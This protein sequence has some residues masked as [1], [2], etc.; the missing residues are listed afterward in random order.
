MRFGAICLALSLLCSAGCRDREAANM[1]VEDVADELAG[2]EIE[3]GLWE[4]TSHVVEVRGPGLPR[5]V[6]NKMIGPRSR[7]RNCITPEQAARPSA[8]FLAAG[9]DP[10]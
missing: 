4:L 1:S 7:I 8:N 9:G 5:E 10:T 2:M 3:P 6:R